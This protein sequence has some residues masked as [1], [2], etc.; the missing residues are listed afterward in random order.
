MENK[1]NRLAQ[2]AS[3]YLKQHADNPVDWYPW[4]EEALA[5]ARREN[6]PILL[7]I[8]YS[9]CHWCHVMAV[10]SFADSATAKIM[11]EHFVNIK[12]DREERPDLDKVYQL[13]QQLLTGRAGGWPLTMFLSP[14]NQTPFFGG[15][16][17]PP[18]S[19]Y[20]LPSFKE[21][22]IKIANYYQSHQNEINQQNQRLEQAL[23]HMTQHTVVADQAITPTILAKAEQELIQSFDRINGGFGH[24][25]KFPHP[26]SL[27]FLLRLADEKN[28]DATQ[29][30]TVVNETLT[31]MARG[32]I[33][34]QIGGGFYRYSVDAE[35]QIPHFEKMLY[36]NGQLLTVYAQAANLF[37][38]ELFKKIAQETAEWILRDMTAPA[39]AFYATLDADAEHVEGKFYYW[40]QGEIR[41]VLTAEEYEV[42]RNYYNLQ[43]PA[44]FEG[45]WH[46]H[47]THELA[48]VAQQCHLSIE[49]ARELVQSA[50]QK[51]LRLRNQKVWPGR[52]EKILTA[53]NALTIKGLALTARVLNKSDLLTAA[54]RAVDFIH[55]NLV[56][57]HRLLACYQ[58]NHAYLPAYLDDYAFLL[59]ALMTLLQCQWRAKDLQLAITL[60]DVLLNQ[61]A[62]EQ[63]GFYFTAHDHE[64]LLQ[65]SKP[66]M[67]EAVP[68]GNGI[69]AFALARLG[70]LLAEPR[71]LAASEKTLKIA[72]QALENYPS[73]YASLLQAVSDYLQPPKLIILRGAG[74]ELQ[75]WQ[76]AC[77]QHM[78]LNQLVFAVP[79]EESYLPGNLAHYKADKENVHAYVCMGQQCL[80]PII[81][82][83]K[84][85]SALQI[86]L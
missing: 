46:L 65:R 54:F 59:D 11:N 70:H 5:K 32:G 36:D 17:F 18:E 4:S 48:E 33:Y 56:K 13:A 20:G 40:G 41:S 43:Q 79:A 15:T 31:K 27:L 64:K 7:S 35:W 10:E 25:P 47:V 51:L 29:A 84:L 14:E 12:V 2:E 60:A 49:R 21:L 9:A 81:E 34:D 63:G 26:M 30:K 83:D 66:L 58:D 8:G 57:D 72:W 28:N 19:R 50:K 69:A 22:L 71:Y 75:Q 6:K 61:F 76:A 24:A 80:E 77:Q 68:A 53:W 73:A 85:I 42:V 86:N 52:D 44:N 23:Q 55:A 78:K 62:A 67:D 16:Y 38:N 3:L 1:K 37:N 39:G 74:T 45:H 82:L